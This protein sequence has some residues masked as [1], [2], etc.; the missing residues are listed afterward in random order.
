[1]RIAIFTTGTRGDIQPFIP[2]AQGLQ[3]AGHAVRLACGGNFRDLVEEAGIDFAP[4]DLDYN[5]ILLSPEIQTA[6]EKGGVNFLRVMLN[7]FPRVFEIYEHALT[8]AWRAGE[9]AEAVLFTANGPWGHHIAEALRVPA[10]YVCLQPLARSREV[11][12]A[13]VLSKNGPGIINLASHI[14]FEFVTWLPFRSRVNRWREQTLHLPALSLRPPYPTSRQTVLG[15]YSQTLSPRPS[16]WPSA[17]RVVG[18]WLSDTPA[19]WRPPD[20][21]AAF[22]D[23]GPAP[24]YL[25]FGSMMTRDTARISRVILEALKRTRNR[26]VVTRGWNNLT[27]ADVPANVFLLPAVPHAWLFPRMAF[28]VHHGGGGTTAAALRSGVPSMAVPYAA[29]QPYWGRRA[30]ALG[31]GPAPVMYKD[32]TAEKLAAAIQEAAGDPAMHAAA[33]AAGEKIR[34]EDGVGNAMELIQKALHDRGVN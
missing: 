34:A 18:P 17:W 20:D 28:I 13:V 26:A 23:A 11:P 8:Q 22:L 33:K 6:M 4:T 5:E 25:G 29:D 27:A 24:V 16:D 14:G 2:L 10:I 32:V 3:Q 9:G 30:H 1:M 21:L 19:G 7:V 31:V 15:A 12:N